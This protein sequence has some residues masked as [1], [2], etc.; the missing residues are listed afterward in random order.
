MH[1][2]T[3]AACEYWREGGGDAKFSYVFTGT[4]GLINQ[5]G[6]LLFHDMLPQS[7]HVE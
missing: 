1:A 6:T 7:T 4:N 5:V 3:L 2:V